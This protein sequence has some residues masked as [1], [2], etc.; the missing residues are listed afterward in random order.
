MSEPDN[1]TAAAPTRQAAIKPGSIAHRAISWMR[2]HDEEQEF[3]TSTL[4]EAIRVT[5]AGVI[6]AMEQALEQ[7]LVQRRQKLPGSRSPFWWSLPRVAA[8]PAYLTQSTKGLDLQWAMAGAAEP[9]PAEAPAPADDAGSDAESEAPMPAPPRP[10]APLAPSVSEVRL[11]P[12]APPRT[13]EEAWSRRGWSPRAA[14][15]G[16]VPAMRQRPFRAALWTD[17]ALLIDVDGAVVVLS[18]DQ[19]QQIRKLMNGTAA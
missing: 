11:V 16:A 9:Q 10:V 8:A 5:P 2:A 13:V 3:L 4:A 19:A 17:G 12:A 14:E 6:A 1:D 7:G 18:P 15:P